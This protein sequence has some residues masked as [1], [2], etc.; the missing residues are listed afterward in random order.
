MMDWD[1]IRIF[2]ILARCE[3]NSG[4]WQ[5]QSQADTVASYQLHIFFTIYWI[6]QHTK[7]ITFAAAGMA[8]MVATEPA[9]SKF[10]GTG[11]DL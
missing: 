8:F 7:R 3:P 9:V 1:N 6:W 10:T 5:A 11:L 2:R 4:D